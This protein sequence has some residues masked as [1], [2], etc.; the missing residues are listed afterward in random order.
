MDF[1]KKKCLKLIK[2]STTLLKRGEYL[3]NL[4]QTKNDQLN[5]YIIILSDNVFWKSKNDYFQIL[6][7]LSEQKITVNEFINQYAIIRSSN[8]NSLEI[9]KKNLETEAFDDLNEINELEIELNPKSFGFTNVL[10]YIDNYIDL[11]DSNIS[12]DVN[13]KN[14]EL[15]GYG[16]SE[17]LFRIEMKDN[18]LP[19]IFEYCKES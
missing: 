11:V 13:I 2:E 9:I 18:F 15:M 10:Y 14:P 4:D 16:I 5:A 17:E 7:L 1:N 12:F 8:L 6:K 3:W 19:I